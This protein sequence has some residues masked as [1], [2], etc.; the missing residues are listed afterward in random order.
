M[1]KTA[2]RIERRIYG[3][4]MPNFLGP[5][6]TNLSCVGVIGTR[7]YSQYVRTGKS[8]HG[9]QGIRNVHTYTQL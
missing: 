2:R 4:E 8:S 1:L 3:I 7:K 5:S 9:N 6:K